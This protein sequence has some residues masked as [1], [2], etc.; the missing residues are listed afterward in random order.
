MDLP[1]IT[2]RPILP[3]LD[4]VYSDSF[5]N[6]SSVALCFCCGLLFLS[7]T[8]FEPGGVPILSLARALTA[9]TARNGLRF[10]FFGTLNLDTTPCGRGTCNNLHCQWTSANFLTKN[11]KRNQQP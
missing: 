1:A 3:R 2:V 9:S 11:R 7:G 5:S 4:T 6:F 10:F 8:T